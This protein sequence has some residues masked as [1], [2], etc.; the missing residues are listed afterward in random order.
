M[1]ER[2]TD[3]C[4]APAAALSLVA[5]YGTL[6]AVALLAALAI[7]VTFLVNYDRIV[8]LLGFSLLCVGTLPDWRAGRMHRWRS[9]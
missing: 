8:V 3:G 1:P 7:G 6:G 2:W 4:L 9:N 5:C